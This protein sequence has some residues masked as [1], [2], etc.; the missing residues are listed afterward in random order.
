[1]GAP[2]VPSPV[3]ASAVVSPWVVSPWVVS[4]WVVV[5]LAAAL[6]DVTPALVVSPG[7]VVSLSAADVVESLTATVSTKHA[8]RS[9]AAA[10]IDVGFIGEQGSIGACSWP[11]RAGEH[12]HARA[13][14][15]VSVEICRRG[16]R[17]EDQRRAVAEVTARPSIG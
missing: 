3:V 10:A 4:P 13:R 17:A 1:V 5:V 9:R 12:G 15:R 14:A 11:S 6:V 7:L 16:G 2:V 8:P